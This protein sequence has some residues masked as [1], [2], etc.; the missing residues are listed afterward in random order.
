MGEDTVKT[1]TRAAE[2]IFV[3]LYFMLIE[4]ENGLDCTGAEG[5]ATNDAPGTY[6]FSLASFY[7][8]G[9]NEFGIL[10]QI[11]NVM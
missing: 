10:S 11:G 5:I 1:P 2:R 8:S 6:C 9:I 3:N 7:A 4:L